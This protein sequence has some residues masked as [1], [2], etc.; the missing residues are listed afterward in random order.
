MEVT[1][2][3]KQDLAVLIV[4]HI[5]N[6]FATVYLS[7]NLIKTINISKTKEGWAIDIPAEI[8]DINLYKKKGVIVHTHNGSYASEV[9]KT[10]GYSGTHVDYV[11]KSISAAINEW[12]LFYNLK[13]RVK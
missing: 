6:N 2:K 3:M 9:D 1:D 7:Q 13:G 5:K 11:N 10:G 12:L 4:K 8:Y